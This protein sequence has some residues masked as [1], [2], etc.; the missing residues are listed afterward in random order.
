MRAPSGRPLTMTV[1]VPPGRPESVCTIA[2]VT[3]SEV[4]NVA[5]S[6]STP[7]RPAD[8]RIRATNPRARDTCSG[9]PGTVTDPKT[10]P[11]GLGLDR[12]WRPPAGLSISRTLPFVRGWADDNSGTAQEP[13]RVY[14]YNA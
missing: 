5:A 7:R 10:A 9:C 11:R 13:D 6:E 8:S 2:F 3:S 14:T 1:T 4:S 12:R